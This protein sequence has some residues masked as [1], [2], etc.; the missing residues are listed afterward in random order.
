MPLL[1][2]WTTDNNKKSSI[3]SFKD[4]P[5]SKWSYSLWLP[6]MNLVNKQYCDSWLLC[7]HDLCNLIKEA[8][9][10]NKTNI[11]T[12]H[13]VYRKVDCIVQYINVIMETA[14]WRMSLP[15]ASDSA[16][17]GGFWKHVPLHIF[18]PYRDNIIKGSA[19]N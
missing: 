2:R 18:K 12:Q 1:L 4:N 3:M 17:C 6:A 5:Y 16:T 9:G 10:E 7:S 11:I 14:H 8:P 13:P 15:W 19:S